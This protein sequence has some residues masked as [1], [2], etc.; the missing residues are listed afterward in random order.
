VFLFTN[1]PAVLAHAGLATTDMALTAMLGACLLATIWWFE[2]PS[3]SRAALLGVAGGLAL[4]SKFSSM[5]FFAAAAVCH[6]RYVFRARARH[7]WTLAAAIGIACVVVWAG[8]RF[9][10]G[11][12]R[13]TGPVRFAPEFFSG[14][15]TVRWHNRIGHLSYL[16]GDFRTTGFP[17]Y[18][19]AALAVKTPLPY[20][21]L[22]LAGAVACARRLR[23]MR[24]LLPVSSALGI[25]AVAMFLGR[26]NIGIR[27]ILPVYL[28]FSLVAAVGAVE[29]L[30]SRKFRLAGVA[31]LGWLFVASAVAHPDYLA[32]FNELA[33]REPE[34]ILIDS[35]LDWGQDM[36]RLGERLHAL[37][38]QRVAF[39]PMLTIRVENYGF[40]TIEKFSP[41][42]PAHGWNAAHITP[43]KFMEYEFRVQH[44]GLKFWPDGIR[45]VERVGK[46]VLL[47]YV[48]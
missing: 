21:L 35:D 8:Y 18:Y 41:D 25:L 23:D 13:G 43:L 38:A 5:P 22:L 3:L 17:L 19:I 6:L 34:K 14:L 30:Q 39:N 4:L 42:A 9:S 36:K 15:K 11:P 48:E 31:L 12:V 7:A 1:L 10:F 45:P 26:I 24:Y 37:G 28:G 33:G 29:I 20:L 32:Y 46:G 2:D 16:M 40:P 47:W 27:H 44:P